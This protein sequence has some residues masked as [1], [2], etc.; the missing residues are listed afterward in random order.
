MASSPF[1]CLSIN[2][3]SVHYLLESEPEARK[4]AI[5]GCLKTKHGVQHVSE[6]DLNACI[7]QEWKGKNASLVE[8]IKSFTTT[9]ED[10]READP[11]IPAGI[12]RPLAMEIGIAEELRA[13]KIFEE[14]LKGVKHEYIVTPDQSKRVLEVSD[15]I[16]VIGRFDA[17]IEK[18][19]G[20]KRIVSSIVEVKT[21]MKDFRENP[22]DLT[23]LTLYSRMAPNASKL[24]YML[25]E[26]LP[27]TKELKKT[28]YPYEKLE[29]HWKNVVY[30]GLLRL[31]PEACELW[32]VRMDSTHPQYIGY[33]YVAAAVALIEKILLVLRVPDIAGDKILI[34]LLETGKGEIAANM[35]ISYKAFCRLI[36]PKVLL[37]IKRRDV[38]F[39]RHNIQ[40]LVHVSEENKEYRGHIAKYSDYLA[41]IIQ[42]NITDKTRDSLW[43]L[44]DAVCATV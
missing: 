14:T 2:A 43:Q 7:Y 3:S 9:V 11:S 36:T 20:D 18:V 29:E 24:I 4:E 37:M 15:S 41:D 27:S 26:Y 31:Y 28:V 17:K 32:R 8:E 39:F 42:K 5:L 25:L 13:L 19:V 33:D 23:Q 6:M 35:E 21:R 16:E 38:D 12:E 34:S 30:P 22:A 10:V 40:S 1:K 44:V